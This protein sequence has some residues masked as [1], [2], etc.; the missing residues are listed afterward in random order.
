MLSKYGF[1]SNSINLILKENP[2]ISEQEVREL[3][4]ATKDAINTGNVKA[5]KAT[6]KLGVP[7]SEENQ[8]SAVMALLNSG[9]D[10][11]SVV[12]TYKDSDIPIGEGEALN[13]SDPDSLSGLSMQARKEGL[14]RSNE[15]FKTAK[16]DKKKLDDRSDDMFDRSE[17]ERER[18]LD[19]EDQTLDDVEESR[20]RSQEERLAAL[21]NYRQSRSQYQDDRVSRTSLMN[22]I[23]NAPSTY[24]EAQ[25]QGHEQSLK[26]TAALAAVLP[27][28]GGG[29]AVKS[30]LDKQQELD[31]NV[32]SSSAVGRLQEIEN[33]RGMLGQ[34]LGQNQ[35]AAQAQQQLDQ[36]SQQSAIAGG[37]LDLQYSQ[38]P[39]SIARSAGASSQADANLALQQRQLGLSAVGLSGNFGQGMLGTNLDIQK[40]FSD[41]EDKEYQKRMQQMQLALGTASA[42]TGGLAD[43][44][45][46][47]KEK[48]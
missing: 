37:N 24:E 47:K 21:E 40:F 48:K 7:K 20:K 18:R 32:A 4:R 6:R 11:K 36:Q 42:F 28:R 43:L 27:T 45:Y 41:E 5:S 17:E 39:M 9:G 13:M 1:T 10:Y 2:N 19:L 23:R 26:N 30:L 34:L 22:E 8:L 3:A 25:R 44:G 12:D 33:R 38:I 35:Q 16:E 31:L 46:G 14:R 15:L 29:S